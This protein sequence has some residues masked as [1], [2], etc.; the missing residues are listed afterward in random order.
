MDGVHRR[1]GG[2]SASAPPRFCLNSVAVLPED[3]GRSAPKNF[4]CGLGTWTHSGQGHGHAWLA[5]QPLNH[6]LCTSGGE[7]DANAARPCSRG[8]RSLPPR[9]EL[10][11]TR[12]RSL[13]R[14]LIWCVD[15][16][17]RSFHC[18]LHSTSCNL[19][20]CDSTPCTWSVA[21]ISKSASARQRTIDITCAATPVCPVACMPAGTYGMAPR[22]S[23]TQLR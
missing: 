1:A 15:S 23:P 13:D 2:A 20:R 16:S 14:P 7:A 10:G 3:N 6:I 9:T 8:G 18:M 11:P 22:H 17:F 12:E 4:E 19:Y 21:D 5:V